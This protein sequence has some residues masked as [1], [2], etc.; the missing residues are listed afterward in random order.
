MARLIWRGSNDKQHLTK[1]EPVQFGKEKEGRRR[2]GSEIIPWEEY[3]SWR[4]TWATYTPLLLIVPFLSYTT[5]GHW[6]SGSESDKTVYIQASQFS[7]L[8]RYEYQ[9]NHHSSKCYYWMNDTPLQCFSL[10]FF[11][12][13]SNTICPGRRLLCNLHFLPNYSILQP[14][15]AHAEHLCHRTGMSSICNKALTIH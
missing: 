4:I 15:P 12:L 5:N 7:F 9:A 11:P 8:I 6:F 1:Y 13:P 2:S 3:Y 14:N 10:F